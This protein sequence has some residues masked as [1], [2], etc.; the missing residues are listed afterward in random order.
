MSS[1]DQGHGFES[2]RSQLTVPFRRCTLFCVYPSGQTINQ[3]LLSL[4]SLT[5]GLVPK[6][7]HILVEKEGRSSEH[8]VS[9]NQLNIV[10]IWYFCLPAFSGDIADHREI[11]SGRLPLDMVMRHNPLPGATSTIIGLRWGSCWCDESIMAYQGSGR[12]VII[13]G[14]G[15]MYSALRRLIETSSSRL[16]QRQSAHCFAL[17]IVQESGPQIS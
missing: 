12:C 15:P 7:S 6:F 14:R 2:Y 3:I 4:S 11:V 17:C 5:A 9:F 10:Y 13:T 8:A 1:A 16:V